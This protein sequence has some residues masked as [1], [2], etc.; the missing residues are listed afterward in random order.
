M[1]IIA[2]SGSTKTHW[3]VIQEKGKFKSFY[4]QGINPYFL[5]VDEMVHIIKECFSGFPTEEVKEVYF[6]GAGCSLQEKCSQVQVSLAKVFSKANIETNSDLLAA[7]HALFGRQS[8]VACI[9]GT[10]S[11]A[12]VYDGEKFTNKIQS[13]GYLLGDEGSGSYIGRQLVQSYFRKEMPKE[14]RAE[15]AKEFNLDS[16]EVLESVYKQPFPNRYLASFALFASKHTKDK[17]IIN[18]VRLSFCDFIKYQLDTLSFNKELPIG[19]V[20]SIAFYF[21]DI[22]KEELESKGYILASVLKN[23]IESLE[24]FYS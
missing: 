19:F 11:N 20:G 7:A 22:L 4:S 17:F 2:D 9:L 18:I 12:A 10:G 5:N 8:G 16:K 6:Y 15:F 13:L 1:K 23:P 14:L 3:I 24:V 21:Q